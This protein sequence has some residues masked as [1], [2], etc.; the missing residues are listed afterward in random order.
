MRKPSAVRIRILSAGLL[1]FSMACWGGKDFGDFYTRAWYLVVDGVLHLA[2]VG[3]YKPNT[4]GLYDMVGNAS[5]WTSTDLGEGRKVTKGG[6]FNDRPHKALL[7]WGYPTWMRPFDVG[8]RV[9]VEE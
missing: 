5:E 7:R 1:L 9:V 6:S 8:F 4:Y 2:L 3:S